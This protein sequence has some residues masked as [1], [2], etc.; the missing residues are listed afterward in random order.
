[1]LAAMLH[2]VNDLRLEEVPT[3]RAENFG[4]VVV[5]IKA[6]GLCATDYKAI[7]G[8]RG[9]VAFPS[10]VGHEPSGIVFEV[11][12]GV[13]N[14]K[15]GEAVI[16]QPLGHCGLCRMCREGNTHYCNSPFVIGGHGPADVRQGAFAEYLLT[17]ENCLFRK[18]KNISFDAAALTEPLATAWKGIINHSEMKIG[19]DAVI[20]G[21]GGIGLLCLMVAKT[22]GA[23]TL[24][25][26]DTREYALQSAL[27]LG[28]THVVNPA[29]EDTKRRI[30]EIMVHGP[31]VMLEAAGSIQAVELMVSLRRHGT[32]WTI[33]GAATTPEKLE[34]DCGLSNFLEGRGDAS[35]GTTQLSMVK[36]IRL[37]RRGLVDTE[38]IISHRFPLS[39]IHEAIE[40]MDSPERNKVILHP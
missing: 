10:I 33:L 25:A 2:G 36:A 35:F 28:A 30:Y 19:D 18:P 4:D 17:K 8:L 22:A 16:V 12:P 37:L 32:R 24:I 23:G 26:V 6:C 15:V 7:K 34:L 1:M 21:V 38:K 31:D 5:Q 20:I 9:N 39:Q 11:G 14:F 3:P 29:K 40:V 27:N 13:S